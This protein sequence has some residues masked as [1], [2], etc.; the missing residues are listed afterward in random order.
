MEKCGLWVILELISKM[1]VFLVISLFKMKESQVRGYNKD[2]LKV[3]L[4]QMERSKMF[5]QGE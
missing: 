1:W 3:N 2:L 4:K 5:Q